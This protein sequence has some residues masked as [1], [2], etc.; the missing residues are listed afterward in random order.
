MTFTRIQPKD[1]LIL[2][3]S[4]TRFLIERMTPKPI[5][6]WNR[7]FR[8]ILVLSL[9]A[10]W[11]TSSG[12]VRYWPYCL[13]Y[14]ALWFFPFSRINEL[15]L[16]FYQDAFQRFTDTPNR[17]EI[18]PIRR[19]ELLVAAYFE[20]AA[21]FGILYF[22]LL[23]QSFKP[24]FSSVIDALYFSAVTITT[25]GYGD[26]LPQTQFAKLACMYEL[27]VGFIVIAFA[28][29]AYFTTSL[30]IRGS[31]ENKTK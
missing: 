19:V 14:L 16:G 29:G 25:V 20:I 30:R 8:S 22:S 15:A 26:I 9:V 5:H 1:G 2:L 18:T 13:G 11:F 12:T 17:T 28:L 10:L 27:A 24:Q 23:G 4:P 21:Q 3:V 31:E 7:V 6:I